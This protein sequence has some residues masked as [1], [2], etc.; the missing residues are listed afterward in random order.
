MP[1]SLLLDA[2]LMATRTIR[3]PGPPR[4]PA[5]PGFADDAGLEVLE[6]GEADV[7]HEDELVGMSG[8][9]TP[10]PD[11]RPEESANEIPPSADAEG[12]AD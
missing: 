9:H 3:S 4:R 5:N 2:R 8:S 11:D 1:A 6:H 10:A 12:G 7:A